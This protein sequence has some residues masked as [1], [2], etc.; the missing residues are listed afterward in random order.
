MGQAR[1]HRIVRLERKDVGLVPA[2]IVF[3]ERAISRGIV[4]R[5]RAARADQ[6]GPG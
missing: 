3:E 6:L 4:A 1:A 5:N 2:Q